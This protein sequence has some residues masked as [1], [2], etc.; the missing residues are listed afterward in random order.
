VSNLKEKGQL[1]DKMQKRR[2]AGPSWQCLAPKLVNRD[3]QQCV[4]DVRRHSA[5]L[6]RGATGFSHIKPKWQCGYT[7]CHSKQCFCI[8]I[9]NKGY[10]WNNGRQSF[11]KEDRQ[12]LE[13][14]H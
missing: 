9:A 13:I 6:D 10:E 4:V 1:R 5:E 14:S 11:G 8:D 3:P 2:S 7:D 12:S